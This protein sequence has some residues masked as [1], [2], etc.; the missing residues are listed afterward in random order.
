MTATKTLE[1]ELDT[2]EE[3][4]EIE[5][6]VTFD[7]LNDGIGHYEYWGQV[8]FDKGNPYLEVS[9]T[10]WDKKGFTAEEI[11]VIEGEIEK[12]HSVWCEE[13]EVDDDVPDRD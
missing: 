7:V 2:R 12:N 6:E 11:A 8:C 10:E 3:C 5:V 13:T 4:V 9:S 1:V